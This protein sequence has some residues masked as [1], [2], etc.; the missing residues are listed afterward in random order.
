M[1]LLEILGSIDVHHHHRISHSNIADVVLLNMFYVAGRAAGGRAQKC[2]NHFPANHNRMAVL[3]AKFRHY[4]PNLVS[5]VEKF[6]LEL[7]DSLQAWRRTVH[8]S[9][10]GGIAPAVQDGLQ[11]Y[12]QGTELPILRLGISDQI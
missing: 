7:L 2:F 8:Q 6:V 3:A 9:H 10:D 5:S 12:P 4:S 1:K 11:P